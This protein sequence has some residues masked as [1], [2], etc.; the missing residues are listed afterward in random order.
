MTIVPNTVIQFAI[1]SIARVPSTPYQGAHIIFP[2]PMGS[3]LSGCKLPSKAFA[4]RTWAGKKHRIAGDIEFESCFQVILP[5][6]TRMRNTQ[7]QLDGD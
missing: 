5:L 2:V 3:T 1:E 4:H 6:D 7:V